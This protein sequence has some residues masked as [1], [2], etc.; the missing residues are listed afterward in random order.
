MNCTRSFRRS[1]QTRMSYRVP[2]ISDMRSNV[3]QRLCRCQTALNWSPN[4]NNFVTLDDCKRKFKHGRPHGAY[5]SMYN[6]IL[7]QSKAIESYRMVDRFNSV[8]SPHWRRKSAQRLKDTHASCHGWPSRGQS[9][10]VCQTTRSKAAGPFFMEE[11]AS[12]RAY[13]RIKISEEELAVWPSVPE[14]TFWH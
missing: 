4:I 5:C 1:C 10:W 6:T 7:S 14:R 9:S 8:L 12:S 11:E 13:C 3:I 2:Y